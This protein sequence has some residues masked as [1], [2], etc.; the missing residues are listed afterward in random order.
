MATRFEGISYVGATDFAEAPGREGGV[1]PSGMDMLTVPFRGAPFAAADFERDLER[2]R[3]RQLGA[4]GLFLTRW[5]HRRTDH[6]YLEYR[7]IYEGLTGGKERSSV[8]AVN[9]VQLVSMQ[10][11]ASALIDTGSTDDKGA[12]IRD[13]AQV[14]VEFEAPTTVYRWVNAKRLS[15]PPAEYS[16]LVGASRINIL[17]LGATSDG[18]RVK[19][20]SVRLDPINRVT[21]FTCENIPYTSYFECESVVQRVFSPS[22]GGAE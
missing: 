5:T 12:T 22:S 3:G 9:T 4:T 7:V 21:S 6:A 18:G 13:D 19:M 17:K 11:A 8:A 1:A 10:V 16:G 15:E 20:G 14:T 2:L